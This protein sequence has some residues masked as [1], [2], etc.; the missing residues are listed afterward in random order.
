ML[1]KEIY[2][3]C[4]NHLLHLKTTERPIMFFSEHQEML[5]PPTI[6]FVLSTL[7]A[8]ADSNLTIHNSFLDLSFQLPELNSSQG[9]I[10][11]LV[12]NPLKY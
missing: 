5:L 12:S 10:Q 6:P 7:T 2:E 11:A 8:A 3:I 1:R 9:N 4:C